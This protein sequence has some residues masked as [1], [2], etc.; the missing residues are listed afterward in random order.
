M[1]SHAFA[2][3]QNPASLKMVICVRRQPVMS[4][5]QFLAY[6]LDNHAPLA[7]SA[8]KRGHAPP[9]LGYMQN[10]TL[11]NTTVA[12]T[13][14]A[15]GLPSRSYDGL[16]EVWLDKIEDLDMSE[17]V[18][19]ALAATNKILIADEAS[20]VDLPDSRVFAVECD[21]TWAKSEAPANVI[22]LVVLLRRSGDAADWPAQRQ[23]E[24][25]AMGQLVNTDA[26]LWGFC[27]SRAVN[28]ALMDS[29]RLMRD[30]TKPPYDDILE[31]WCDP[32]DIDAYMA[33]VCCRVLELYE[34]SSIDFGDSH[35]Y[36]TQPYRI[37]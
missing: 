34:N 33:S 17:Q 23:R 35:I 16:T 3:L 20:F 10:H 25:K 8:Y 4:L 13:A 24:I 19:E 5:P 36:L 7:L 26:S 1:S 11:L 21:A 9:M 32:A 28:S 14:K 6:W 30:M 27:Q 37:F 31:L 18:S 12:E 2:S 22:K 15:Y 29:F